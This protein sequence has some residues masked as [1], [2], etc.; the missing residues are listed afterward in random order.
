MIYFDSDYMAGAHPSVMKR[1]NETNLLETPGYGSDIFC[2]NARQLILDACGLDNGEVF[3]MT[4]GTQ[5][6]ATVIDRLINRNDGVLAADTSHI[7]VHEAGAI[8]AWGH[9]ILVLQNH[10][11]KI[12]AEQVHDYITEFYKDDT[13][14]HMVR[15]AMVYISFPTEL[16]T[17]YSRK[18]LTDLYETC[19]QYEIPLYIDGARLTYGLQSPKNDLTLKEIAHLCDVFYI[20]GTKCGLLFGEAVVTKQPSLLNR[21]ISL[22]KLHGGLLA[23]GRL[24]GVQF[25]TLFTDS[26]YD[27]IG[28]HGISMAMEIKYIFKKQG[29][30]IFIDSHTNQQFFV[31]PNNIIDK[32]KE[33]VSFEL[34]GAKG[35][36]AT[37]VRFVT[38]WRTTIEDIQKLEEILSVLR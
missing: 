26:L 15:P 29:Y 11:G 32:L 21:F 22:M 4:G 17:I 36:K 2:K 9:K 19:Q 27:N 12:T 18:E 7:N 10:N 35:E 24:L 8:E 20:G 34:W 23:K 28:K 6:N 13:F 25:E 5:S 38:S 37:P 14:P 16:G 30:E 33:S 1:L 3:F 31:L